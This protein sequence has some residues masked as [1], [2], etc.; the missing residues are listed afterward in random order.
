LLFAP[1][2]PGAIGQHLASQHVSYVDAVGN[3]HVETR[4]MLVA[5]IEGKKPVR[6]PGARPPGVTSHQLLFALLAEPSLVEA[7]VRK[8]ALAAGIGRS[9]ALEQLGRL[10]M[11]GLLDYYPAGGL[12]QGRELLDRWLTAYAEAVRPSWLVARC[13]PQLNDPRAL[14]A[15]I[16]RVCGD[17]IWAFGGAAAASRMLQFERGTET[18]L[19]LSEIPRDLLERLR[20]VPA[21]D[22]R[23]AAHD[24]VPTCRLP[25]AGLAVRLLDRWGHRHA[26]LL[27][28][29]R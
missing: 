29:A 1:Y 4:E 12:L 3:C 17:G 2:V 24:C 5:H 9:A 23:L 19:H 16:E 11:Q 18:V 13:R 6:E 28:H 20:A 10:N 25:T 21:A 14:E 8:V 27:L 7:P 22:C 15:L 26:R